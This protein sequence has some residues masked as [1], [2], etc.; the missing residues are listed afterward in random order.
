MS[1]E[2]KYDASNVEHIGKLSP[3]AEVATTVMAQIEEERNQLE[4]Q[5]SAAIVNRAIALQTGVQELM[6]KIYGQSL[7]PLDT[8]IVAGFFRSQ[9][10]FFETQERMGAEK[11]LRMLEIQQQMA[12]K[13]EGVD[14]KDMPKLTEDLLNRFNG[15][16]N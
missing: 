3:E 2:K 6:T 4:M 10:T 11:N 14:G 15:K 8:L 13:T 7:G 5:N 1:E 12:Q 16:P 9:I